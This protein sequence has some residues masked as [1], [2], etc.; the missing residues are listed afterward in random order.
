MNID[1]KYV[2]FPKGYMP[3][4]GDHEFILPYPNGLSFSG[5]SRG[6]AEFVEEYLTVCFYAS[7]PN[8]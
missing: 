2:M 3:S 7:L 1:V 4:A 6:L 5:N 8:P